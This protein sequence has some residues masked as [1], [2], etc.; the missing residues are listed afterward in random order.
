MRESYQQDGGLKF[1]KAAAMIQEIAEA[2]QDIMEVP[3]QCSQSAIGKRKLNIDTNK[4]I[5]YL[6][7]GCGNKR[8]KVDGDDYKAAGVFGSSYLSSGTMSPNAPNFFFEMT[9]NP[10]DGPVVPIPDLNMTQSF[11]KS[12][13]G[14]LSI[15]PPVAGDLL[16]T[17]GFY[18]N[19][20]TRWVSVFAKPTGAASFAYLVA[21]PWTQTIATDYDLLRHAASYVRAII[22]TYD[23]GASNISGVFYGVNTQSPVDVRN[24][25]Q[26]TIQALGNNAR[27]A[28]SNVKG[29]D[30]I[31]AITPPYGNYKFKVPALTT[32]S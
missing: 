32:R 5:R 16:I 27:S 25:N 1:I 28:K 2:K 24:I 3:E 7:A 31:I 14:S 21:F 18:S 9:V 12:V 19:D 13:T 23:G 17:S 15:T 6:A 22:T 10:V 26:S 8:Q 29:T 30:G 4:A 20:Q 11:L